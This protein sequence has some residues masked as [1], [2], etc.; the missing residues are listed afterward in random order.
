MA[1]TSRT[2]AVDGLVAADSLEG[3]L[4][5][6]A[7][8]LHLGVFVDFSNFIEKQGAPGRLFKTPGAALKGSGEGTFLMAEKL[9]FQ[10]VLGKRASVDGDELFVG[11]I[12]QGVN[13]PG[14]EFLAGTRLLP[15]QAQWH[16]RGATCLIVSKTSTTGRRLPDKVLQAGAFLHLAAQLVVFPPGIP[17]A[18][19]AVDQ[20]FR[21]GRCS[22]AW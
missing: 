4:A 20:H 5:E 11:A 13:G 10:Q 12:A 15:G 8:D 21:A 3:A 18:Y 22:L 17:L 9:A 16:G 1:A 19:G 6:D 2:S 7:E 14:G